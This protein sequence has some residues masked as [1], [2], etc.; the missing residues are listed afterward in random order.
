MTNIAELV[1]YALLPHSD[2]VSKPRALNTFL[3]GI[4]EI[5]VD[6]GLIKNKKALSSL[7]EKKATEICVP[8]IVNRNF[9]NGWTMRAAG[10]RTSIITLRSRDFKSWINYLSTTTT[11]FS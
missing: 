4:A 7:I 9:N 1:E 8:G 10:N 3:D 6:R 5:G 11:T 2:S